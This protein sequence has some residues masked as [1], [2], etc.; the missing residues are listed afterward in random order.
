M[1]K[2]PLASDFNTDDIQLSGL[3]KSRLLPRPEGGVKIDSAENALRLAKGLSSIF[4]AELYLRISVSGMIHS[5]PST[6]FGM[7]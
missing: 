3:L 2:S 5:P 6:L 7:P 4:D 1:R